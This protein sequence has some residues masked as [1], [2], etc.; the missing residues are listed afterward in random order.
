M[1]AFKNKPSKERVAT[2]Q[3]VIKRLEN[4]QANEDTPP[5]DMVDILR[6]LRYVVDHITVLEDELEI[7]EDEDYEF[8]EA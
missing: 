4:S 8:E 6:A 5:V 7:I 2:L 3:R 1:V